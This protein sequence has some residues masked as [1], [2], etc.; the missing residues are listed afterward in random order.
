MTKNKGGSNAVIP[1]IVFDQ[2]IKWDRGVSIQRG[3]CIQRMIQCTHEFVCLVPVDM[4]M[5]VYV[6]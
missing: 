1:A 5:T 2:N 3:S 6:P 4:D